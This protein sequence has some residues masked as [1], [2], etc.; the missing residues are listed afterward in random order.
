MY[1]KLPYVVFPQDLSSVLRVPQASTACYCPI[2]GPSGG[3]HF[4]VGD[5]DIFSALDQQMVA[6]LF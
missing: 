5:F 6:Y 1:L 2:L 3:L 4:G